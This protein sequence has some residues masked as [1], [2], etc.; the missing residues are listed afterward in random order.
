MYYCGEKCIKYQGYSK[1]NE[2]DFFSHFGN[3]DTPKLYMYAEESYTSALWP[4][5]FSLRAPNQCCQIAKNHQ[6][7]RIFENCLKSCEVVT[8]FFLVVVGEGAEIFIWLRHLV[9]QFLC[10]DDDFRSLQKSFVNF[11][12]CSLKNFV[13]HSSIE[14]QFFCSF[15]PISWLTQ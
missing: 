14:L 15:C 8:E 6:S 4:G 13:V 7:M 9:E 5:F 2:A 12:T 10:V 3:T 1:S 11:R